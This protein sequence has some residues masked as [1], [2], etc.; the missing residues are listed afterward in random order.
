MIKNILHSLFNS[1]FRTIGRIL[2][3]IALAILF[4]LL[5]GKCT[6]AQT[7]TW[8]VSTQ[9]NLRVCTSSNCNIESDGTSVIYP[10]STNYIYYSGNYDVNSVNVRYAVRN[11]TSNTD[12]TFAEDSYSINLRF[13]IVAE[14]SFTPTKSNFK[15]WYYIP[16]NGAY[17]QMTCDSGE[18]FS[19]TK[20]STSGVDYLISYSCAR[21]DFNQSTITY[22]AYSYYVPNFVVWQNSQS[23]FMQGL[24]TEAT[25]NDIISSDK[26]NT[27]DI[28][29]NNNSNTDKIISSQDKTTEAVKENTDTNK[30]ILDTIK[31]FFGSFFSNLVNGIFG[32]IVPDNFDFLNNFLD[33]LESKLGFIASVPIQLIKFLIDLPNYAF[34]EITTITMP[35]IEIMGITWWNDMVIDF[36]PILN[37]LK[38]FRYFTDITAVILFVRGLMK[39]YDGFTNGGG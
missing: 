30:G 29:N 32:L 7:Y 3:Y 21:L 31:S 16:S 25:N 15:L 1:F 33:T 4:M 35:S 13:R 2:A 19:Y 24:S 10:G 18:E 8:N 34:E 23:F 27:Q 37:E 9:S 14:K 28:I 22:V 20:Q 5:F 11:N 38:I 39:Y 6:F 17:K 26:Q 36:T 12:T